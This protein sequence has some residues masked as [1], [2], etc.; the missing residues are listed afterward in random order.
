MQ[1]QL[2][3]WCHFYQ[4]FYQSNPHFEHSDTTSNLGQ[5]IFLLFLYSQLS[6]T[7]E[8]QKTLWEN[9]KETGK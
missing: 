9:G 1:L 2:Q 3:L 5:V 8:E 7:Q 4:L 6:F